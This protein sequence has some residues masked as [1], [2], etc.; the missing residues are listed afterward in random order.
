MF[1]MQEGEHSLETENS[2]LNLCP[3]SVRRVP[4]WVAVGSVKAEL[5]LEKLRSTAREGPWVGELQHVAGGGEGGLRRKVRCARAHWRC[6]PGT[7]SRVLP[8]VW[9][10][11]SLIP[12]VELNFVRRDDADKV[13]IPFC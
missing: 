5:P 9:L 4:A 6:G 13:L 12:N 1:E 11:S 10:S 3:S 7:G 2:V 8:P